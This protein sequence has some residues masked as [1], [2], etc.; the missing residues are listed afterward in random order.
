V[1]A[2]VITIAAGRHAHLAR[3]TAA[4]ASAPAPLRVVVAMGDDAE[5]A[6]CQA[7]AGPDADVLR[8][9]VAPLGLPLA[10][11]RNLG[12]RH[13]LD[14]GAD[15]LVFL[16]VDCLP[17]GTLLPRYA[18]AAQARPGDLLCGPVGYLPP[19]PA[20]GYPADPAALARLAEPHPARP[21]PP[22]DE[23]RPG[24][25]HRLFWTLSFA[26]TASTWHAIGGFDE[27]Y[28]GYGGEDTDFGQR[29]RAAGVG[30]TWVGGAWAFHQHHA[31][32]PP[33]VAH[34][35]DILRNATLFRSRWGWTPM[36]GWIETAAEHA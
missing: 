32:T 22:E 16:D 15:L 30:L 29:A 6:A 3:Q 4:L 13:A 24:G 1:R 27:A 21:V 5:H 8:I 10:A 7:A 26:I 35:A 12:A 20:G 23:L 25:D 33:A 18:H 34:A 14:R 28:V 19:P 36:E 17:S 9:P 31:A 2:A 11:A